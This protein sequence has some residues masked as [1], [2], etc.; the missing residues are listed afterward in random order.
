MI[1]REDGIRL[2]NL[3]SDE[4]RQIVNESPD[5]L[6]EFPDFLSGV[7]RLDVP[8]YTTWGACDD[9]WVVEL[10]RKNRYHI[11]NL[12]ILDESHTVVLKAGALD[13]RL[14]GIGG[15]LIQEK[16]FDHRATGV[17]HYVPSASITVS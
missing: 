12:H 1:P 11:P 16:F 15:A 14:F 9:L 5:V 13:L 6:S 17:I 3:S 7:K 2:S 4:L 8:V 10:L